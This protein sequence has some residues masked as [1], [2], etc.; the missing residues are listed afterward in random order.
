L[1]C[2]I[3]ESRNGFMSLPTAVAVCPIATKAEKAMN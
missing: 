1:I 2:D 3:T